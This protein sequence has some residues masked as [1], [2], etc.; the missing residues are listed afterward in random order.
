MGYLSDEIIKSALVL[1]CEVNLITP[2]QAEKVASKITSKFLNSKSFY[3]YPFCD[4]IVDTVGIHDSQSW[5]WISNYLS[6]EPVIIFFEPTTDK[7][8]VTIENGL[9]LSTILGECFGFVY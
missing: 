8:M 7:S 1:G 9:N 6:D 4:F 5:S 2:E 3:C